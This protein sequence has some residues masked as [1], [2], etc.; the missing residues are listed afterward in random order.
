M[1]MYLSELGQVECSDLFRLLDLLLVGADL[2]LQLID[3][4][5]GDKATNQNPGFNF[6][7]YDKRWQA[8]RTTLNFYLFRLFLQLQSAWVN[9]ESHIYKQDIASK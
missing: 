4:G 7:T 6:P 3:Q 5:L 9:S 2:G 1:L 8:V